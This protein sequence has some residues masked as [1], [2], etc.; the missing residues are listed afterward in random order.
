MKIEAT[1]GSAKKIIF[2]I[3]FPFL[4]LA[5]GCLVGSREQKEYAVT[6]G[7]ISNFERLIYFLLGLFSQ[8]I[9]GYILSVGLACVCMEG[10]S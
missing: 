10:D 5:V 7:R 1:L 9:S 4:T 3:L 8:A 6:R 2:L